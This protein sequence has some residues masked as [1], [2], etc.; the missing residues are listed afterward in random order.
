MKTHGA[1]IIIVGA[2]VIGCAIAY[3]LSKEGMKVVVVEQDSLGDHAS[4][5]SAGLL[6]PKPRVSKEVLRPMRQESYQMH[7]TLYPQLKEESGVD[8]YFH[9]SPR[10]ELAFTE[11]E[12]DELKSQV[13]SGQKQWG[14][15][16]WL[17]KDD[18]HNLESRVSDEVIG[19]TYSEEGG[20]VDSYRFCLALAQ[21]AEKNGA[22]IRHGQVIGLGKD[23]TRVTAVKLASHDIPCDRVML[24]M[25]PWAEM[26]SSWLG[27]PIPVKPQKGQQLRIRA[28]GPP[29]L[30]SLSWPGGGA[31][32]TPTKHSGL[33][34]VG[35][36]HEDAGFDKQIT[37]E[38]KTGII[39]GMLTMVPSLEDAELELQTACLRP[40][41]ADELPIIGKVSGYDNAYLATG[42]WTSGIIFSPITARIMTDL[43]IKGTTHVSIEPFAP[44]RFLSGKGR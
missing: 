33:L 35:A 44:D 41:S 36:T 11:T 30:S 31:G 40:L 1:D 3:F 13:D 21:A 8:Y 4:G 19:A 42:H 28:L 26:A 32:M 7:K 27:I 15:L 22:E 38:G 6:S 29:F 39:N 5:F 14:K 9:E 34:Y 12:A 2:G 20:R 24:A 23:G 10:M 37:E 17:D 16:R 43:I 25:G 18:V